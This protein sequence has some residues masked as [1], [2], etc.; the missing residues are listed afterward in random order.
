MDHY[1]LSAAPETNKD[2]CVEAPQH[3]VF[4][5]ASLW[6][7]DQNIHFIGIDTIYISVISAIINSKI[8]DIYADIC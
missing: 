5:C 3:K 8:L 4:L 1:N 2:C 7:F 6:Q